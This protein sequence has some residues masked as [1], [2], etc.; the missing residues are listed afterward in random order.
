MY[1]NRARYILMYD[2]SLFYP[3]QCDFAQTNRGGFKVRKKL[4]S[5]F[6][7]KKELAHVWQH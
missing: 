6:F 5:G 2:N 7:I 1:I 3:F 4:D